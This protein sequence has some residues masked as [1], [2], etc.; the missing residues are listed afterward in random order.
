MA[1]RRINAGS[2]HHICYRQFADPNIPATQRVQ[3]LIDGSEAETCQGISTS[4]SRLDKIP[5]TDG[6][7]L[8]A[9]TR[10]L[11]VSGRLRF[12]ED[13]SCARSLRH[14]VNVAQSTRGKT[15]KGFVC[16]KTAG[17]RIELRTERFS[18]FI[19][20]SMGLS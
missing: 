10:N 5:M 6:G 9:G 13:R 4:A 11:R 12:S 16:E 18:G 3:I 7:R 2:L 15:L 1:S 19:N 17:V 14:F 20:Q 8:G